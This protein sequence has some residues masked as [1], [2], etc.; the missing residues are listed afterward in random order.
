MQNFLTWLRSLI[1]F[2]RREQKIIDLN[3]AG[4]HLLQSSKESLLGQQFDLYIADDY[5]REFQSFC[6]HLL[7]ALAVQSSRVSVKN[8]SWQS[9]GR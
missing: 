3:K 1:S 6:L 4:I 5:A 2:S 8:L 7:D 9:P